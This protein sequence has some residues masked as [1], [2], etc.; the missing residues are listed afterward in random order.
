[1]VKSEKSWLG[2]KEVEWGGQA[3]PHGRGGKCKRWR[4][5]V[6]PAG[7]VYY[8]VGGGALSMLS[9]ENKEDVHDSTS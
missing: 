3:I 4:A 5:R 7:D 6:E 2:W 1:L 9:Y 8:L